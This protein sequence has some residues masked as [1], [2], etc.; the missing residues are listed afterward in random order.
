MVGRYSSK[1]KVLCGNA[2]V[3]MVGQLSTPHVFSV[4]EEDCK[5]CAMLISRVLPKLRVFS[6][7]GHPVS[8]LVVIASSLAPLDVLWSMTELEVG[9]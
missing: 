3:Q 5:C 4:E 1:L 6:E 2:K 8:F 7:L 9:P